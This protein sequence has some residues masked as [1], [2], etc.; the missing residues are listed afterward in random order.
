MKNEPRIHVS[1]IIPVKNDHQRL[2]VCL[3]AIARQSFP[4][5]NIEVIVVDDASSPPVSVSQAMYPFDL[6]IVRA[7]G[8]GSYAAR[9]R[10]IG[11]A[12]GSVLAFTDADCIP[13]PSWIEEGVLAVRTSGKPVGGGIVVRKVKG[14]RITI[15][16]AYDLQ[17]SFP[18]RSFVEEHGFAATANLFVPIEA[19]DDVGWFDER[20][21]A[22][23]DREWGVR[24]KRQGWKVIF[25]PES[26]VCH[27]PRRSLSE[28]WRRHRR[29][30]RGRQTLLQL[31]LIN[32]GVPRSRIGT[33]LAKSNA[34][35][36]LLAA[37]GPFV[38]VVRGLAD[39]SAPADTLTIRCLAGSAIAGAA[40]GF[41]EA[42][43]A[44]KRSS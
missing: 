13:G 33:I 22:G 44:L 37:I 5:G 14:D 12:R 39:G 7:G 15:A 1:I 36:V 27:P 41:E 11:V 38:R 42:R 9:N 21:I 26:E 3:D 28:L 18:Q 8:D 32:R 35:R 19:I 31:G 34:G 40:A 20:L 2:R 29:V 23:G 6:R 4:C 17:F 10:G 16:E 43:V 30:S 25:D 24:A